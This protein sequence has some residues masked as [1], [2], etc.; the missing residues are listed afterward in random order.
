MAWQGIEGHDAIVRRFA[1]AA[2]RGRVGGSY[3]F[4]GQ[5][6]VGK[7]TFAL[8]LAKAFAC[9][10]VGPGLV[11]CGRCASCVQADAGSHPDIDVVAKP[12]DRSSIP[13]EAF[14][15]PPDNRMR[16]GL[17]WR[18]KLR[19]AVGAR[20]TAII[21][22][23]D[24][25][26][27]EAANC[28]LKTL[29]EP[30]DGAVIILVG[31][32]LERQL[33]TIRS[34]CQTIRFAPLDRGVIHDLLARERVG[35]TIDP[36]VL[37]AAAASGGSLVRGRLLL[38]PAVTAF[39]AT[40]IQALARRPLPGVELAR[41]TIALV[42]AAGKEAPPRRARLRIVLETALEF[43]RAA[44]RDEAAG[45]RPAD[46][47]LARAVAAQPADTDELLAALQ[48]TLT[49]LSAVDR[50]ANPAA[51]I[52]A[53]TAMIEEPRLAQSARLA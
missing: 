9:H 19:P 1:A 23:A 46:P 49:A 52:D 44:I 14:I 43:F 2:E 20:K 18:I 41:E 26:L 12:E 22:D 47:V 50:N 42:D 16:E 39:R 40:L 6:G 29:E 5:P 36:T 10:A 7:G 45:D 27:D 11:P 3:L 15:G 30:P 8:A 31:T 13:L 48:Q 17:C 53:W 24:A 38:D 34:R 4:V 28:L 33:P 51:V 37:D 32:S 21:L 25:L 35:E